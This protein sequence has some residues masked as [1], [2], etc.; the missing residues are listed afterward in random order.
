MK[1]LI[2]IF[3]LLSV[4]SIS[5]AQF[6]NSIEV[7]REEFHVLSQEADKILHPYDSL[8]N[9]RNQLNKNLLFEIEI[10][11]LC[12]TAFD[13]KMLALENRGDRIQKKEISGFIELELQRA[14]LENEIAFTFFSF[15]S[16]NKN[17]ISGLR[18]YYENYVQSEKKEIYRLDEDLSGYIIK[19]NGLQNSADLSL[20]S[21]DSCRLNCKAK[22]NCNDYFLSYRKYMD[23]SQKYMDKYRVLLETRIEHS[24]SR[25]QYYR[26]YRAKYDRYYTEYAQK[27]QNM[28]KRVED[29][30][31]KINLIEPQ[32]IKRKRLVYDIVYTAMEEDMMKYN[33]DIILQIEKIDE[34]I[35]N[36]FSS[37]EFYNSIK[38]MR[39]MADIMVTTLN[40]EMNFLSFLDQIA[41]FDDLELKK[42]SDGRKLREISLQYADVLDKLKTAIRDYDAIPYFVLNAYPQYANEVVDENLDI[43]DNRL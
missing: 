7:I 33:K 27:R 40:P 14:E 13:D 23:L 41:S 9:L 42:N 21:Y 20:K 22:C 4:I 8:I 30:Q 6:S 35:K 25:T 18:N 31:K 12:E 11:R 17:M 38:D 3:C 10:H 1:K 32:L 2:I 34:K 15:N 19:I 29:I 5:R 43:L 26:E 37:L 16:W 28:E 39:R 24:S 36:E